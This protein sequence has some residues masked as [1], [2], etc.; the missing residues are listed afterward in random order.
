MRSKTV[1]PSAKIHYHAGFLVYVDGTLQDFSGDQYMNIDFCSI[2]HAKETP[3]EI[4][5]GKAHLHDNVG[6]VV[7]VHRPGAVWGDL[8]TNIHYA[9]PAGKPIAGYVNGQAVPDILRDPIKPYD[10]VII[11]VG[12]SSTVDLTNMVPK[13]HMVDVEKHSEGCSV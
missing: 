6:D 13:S 11:T 8:F 4:Q 1:S 10:S 9:F 5:I 7:H 12:D 2:P 3:Q